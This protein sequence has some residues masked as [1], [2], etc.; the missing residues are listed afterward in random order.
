MYEDVLAETTVLR[1]TL[2]VLLSPGMLPSQ[3]ISK[4]LQN[5]SVQANSG[6]S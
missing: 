1:S 3:T 2:L 6:K 4:N 5:D